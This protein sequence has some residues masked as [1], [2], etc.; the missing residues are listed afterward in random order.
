MPP[1]D[2][3]H[4]TSYFPRAVGFPKGEGADSF[5]SIAWR[6]LQCFLKERCELALLS[7]FLVFFKKNKRVVLEWFVLKKAKK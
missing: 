3:W 1:V 4:K 2:S 7:F 5:D 6:M